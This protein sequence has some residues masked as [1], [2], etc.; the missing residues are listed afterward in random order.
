MPEA[1]SSVVV[2]AP[3]L[4][5]AEH[6]EHEP[7]LVIVKPITSGPA[8]SNLLIATR[9]GQEVNLRLISGGTS[10]SSDPVDFVLIYRPRRSFLIEERANFSLE[11]EFQ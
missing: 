8:V 3:N 9:S 4:F 7:E 5:A 1:V 2:G 6:S 11:P 10:A